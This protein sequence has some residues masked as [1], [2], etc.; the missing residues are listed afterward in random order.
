MKKTC[1]KC[2]IEKHVV[3]FSKNK[4]QK[5]DYCNQCKECHKEYSKNNKDKISEK[6]K[7]YYKN[8]KKKCIE[9]SKK[10]NKKYRKVVI[11]HYTKGKNTC[12][13]YEGCDITDPDMLAIDHINNDGAE[14]RRKVGG[15]GNIVVKWL[16]KN[17]FPLGFQIL[18]CNHNQK[19]GNT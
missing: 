5:S 10:Y 11:N 6:K 15:S 18:C 3:F 17:N 13:W 7:E 4:S 2:K 1:S 19:K 14:H 9:N 8:N 16:I 12:M